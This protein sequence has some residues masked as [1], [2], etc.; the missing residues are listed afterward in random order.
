MIRKAT[1]NL[2]YGNTDHFILAREIIQRW[3]EWKKGVCCQIFTP[4]K[5]EKK[6]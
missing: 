4:K 6:P 3:P 5:L 1:V 2:S